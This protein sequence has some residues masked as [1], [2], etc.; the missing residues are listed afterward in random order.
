[1]ASTFE[2][3][4]LAYSLLLP[5]ELEHL[6]LPEQN[7]LPINLEVAQFAFKVLQGSFFSL[8]RLKEDSAFPSILAA[9]FVIKWECSMSLPIDDENDSEGHVEDVD[10][11]SS[12]RRSSKDYVDEKMHLKANLAESIHD[13][14]QS[15]SPAFWNNLPSCTLNRFVNI[16]AQSVRYCV[17]QTRDLHAEK[18]AVLCCE[19]VVEMLKLIC[20]DDINLQSFFDLLL[21]EGEHWPLWLKPCFKNGHASVKVQLE[22]AITDEI[23]RVILSVFFSHILASILHKIFE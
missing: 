19:W 17:F 20:L 22:P 23:V 13:F 3:P 21:S 5:S 11:G 4:R 6:K 8:R 16:L 1:M 9:L 18:T 14:S 12:M 2:W 15:L 10:V 7:A